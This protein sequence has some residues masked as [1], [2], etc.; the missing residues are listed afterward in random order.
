MTSLTFQSKVHFHQTRHGRKRMAMGVSPAPTS[1]PSGRVPRLSR[2]MALAV[3]FDDLLRQGEIKDY[4]D[5][6]RLGHV[7]RARATQIMNLLNLA[8]GIQE[9]ILF[10]P[11]TEAGR[12]AIKE[13]QVRPIAAEPDWGK[14][15]KMWRKLTMSTEQSPSLNERTVLNG[16]RIRQGVRERVTAPADSRSRSGQTDKP[17]RKNRVENVSMQ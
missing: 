17:K 15:Q 14:Q 8:P 5:L 2:L 1:A 9:D 4:A 6:A 12:D 7:T 10:L 3:R 13:W 16:S 11:L